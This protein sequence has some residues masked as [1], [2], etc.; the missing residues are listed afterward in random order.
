MA[1]DAQT[2]SHDEGHAHAPSTDGDDLP[3]HGA[4]LAEPRSPTWLPLLGLAML[5]V[6]VVWWLSTP[7]D[8]EER[9]AA[10]AASASAAAEASASAA[11]AAANAPAPSV[12]A[13]AQPAPPPRPTPAP[14]APPNA[15]P[16][17][18]GFVPAPKQP[19]H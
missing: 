7:S 8:A 2:S 16:L 5:A 13:S 6:L 11:A 12:I 4:A 1:N 17:P 15:P 18:N 14:N 9:A 19:I 10:A 3:H